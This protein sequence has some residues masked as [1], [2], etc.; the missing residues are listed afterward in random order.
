MPHFFNED[1][2]RVFLG[3]DLVDFWDEVLLREPFVEGLSVDF[4]DDGLR[5]DFLAMPGNR[6]QL[7]QNCVQTSNDW[8]KR[9]ILGEI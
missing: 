7:I 3:D 2:G 5:P 1:L 6:L 8:Y 9:S 4:W